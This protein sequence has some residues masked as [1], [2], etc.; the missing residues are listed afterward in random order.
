MSANQLFNQPQP[1]WIV[2]APGR[3]MWMAGGTCDGD[4]Y[5]LHGADFDSHATFSH[6]S[7]KS[8]QTVLKRPLPVW[9]RYPAG[10]VIALNDA[11]LDVPGLQAVLLGDEPHG[12]RYDFGL[13]LV[14]AAFCHELVGARYTPDE[15]VDIV[16]AVRRKYLG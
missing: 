13:G 2:Q 4:E 10:V 1:D 3:E 5:T 9:A 7:A 8:K 15:L 11:G 12:P 6:R 14:V 16:E